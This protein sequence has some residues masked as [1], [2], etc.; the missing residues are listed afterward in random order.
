MRTCGKLCDP[1]LKNNTWWSFVKDR[2]SLSRQD[3]FPPLTMPDGTVATS[4][5]HR[6]QLLDTLFA[7]KMEMNDPE[8]SRLFWNSSVERLSPM[9]R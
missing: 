6:V 7:G 1:G 8:R 3:T 2:Q 4:S 5:N 9:W